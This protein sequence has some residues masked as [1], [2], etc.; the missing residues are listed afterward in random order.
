MNFYFSKQS[1]LSAIE[2]MLVIII[3]M[4][5][6]AMGLRLYQANQQFQY[7]AQVKFNVDQ[8]FEALANYYRAN[9]SNNYSYTGAQLTIGTLDQRSSPSDPFPITNIQTTLVTPGYLSNWPFATNPIVDSAAGINK[10][11]VAQF[12]FN[13]A[14]YGARVMRGLPE[15]GVFYSGLPVGY[16]YFW[17]AQVAIKLA[18]PSLANQYKNILAADCVSSL[19]GSTVLPCSSN[20]PAGGYLVWERLPSLAITGRSSLWVAMPRVKQFKEQYTNDSYYEATN[21][22]YALTQTYLCGG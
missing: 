7:T 10:G 1:G 4:T 13:T 17:K 3:S 2:M 20:P 14:G 21:N 19:S 5:M 18:K 12:N 16:I 15:S 8:I 9:C 6:L 22:G 11:Y